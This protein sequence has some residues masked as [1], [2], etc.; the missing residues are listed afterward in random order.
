MRV[1][2]HAKEIKEIKKITGSDR[3][4]IQEDAF[5]LWHRCTGSADVREYIGLPPI[6]MYRDT[7]EALKKIDADKLREIIL[8][9]KD[10]RKLS[11]AERHRDLWKG[12][13]APIGTQDAAENERSERRQADR[14]RTGRG[15]TR[16][17]T[18][19]RH[20]EAHR[21]APS[22]GRRR[23]HEVPRRSDEKAE[24]TRSIG[25]GNRRRSDS[26]SQGGEP[27]GTP[28]DSTRRP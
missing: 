18:R 20:G 4:D 26:E 1:L 8:D 16:R 6:W 22:T 19:R 27:G 17:R 14:R 24:K 15:E 10:G 23:D 28:F 5:A 2:N 11:G 21:L 25:I 7:E 9:L 12:A 13:Q 3:L